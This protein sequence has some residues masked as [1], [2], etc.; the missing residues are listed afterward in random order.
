MI[1]ISCVY[2]TGGWC[3]PRELACVIS[4]MRRYHKRDEWNLIVLTDDTELEEHLPVLKE[5]NFRIVPFKHDWPGWWSKIELFRPDLAYYR[6]SLYID[7]DTSIVGHLGELWDKAVPLGFGMLR[8]FYYP[9][10]ASG[11]MM[12]QGRADLCRLYQSFSMDPKKYMQAHRST[13][14]QGYIASIVTEPD[15]YFQDLDTDAILTFKP[16]P[17]TRQ[18]TLPKNTK[19]ICFHGQ[20]RPGDRESKRHFQWVRDYY[21]VKSHPEFAPRFD[22]QTLLCAGTGPTFESDWLK[23]TEKYPDAKIASVGYAAG[24]VPADFVFSD[25][26]EV[27]AELAEIRKKL[28]PEKPWTHHCPEI[29]LGAM[30][31]FNLPNMTWWD[32]SRSDATSIESAMRFG[33]CTGFEKVVLCGCPLVKAPVSTVRQVI[34]DGQVWPPPTKRN[35]SDEKLNMF[36]TALVSIAAQYKGRVFSMSGFTRDIFGLPPEFVIPP[37]RRL[38]SVLCPTRK[39]P[40]ALELMLRS[41]RSTAKG[42]VEVLLYIDP[43]EDKSEYGWVFKYRARLFQGKMEMSLGHIWNYLAS[44]SNGEY[45]MMANDDLNFLTPGWDIELKQAMSEFPDELG[46]AWADDQTGHAH[47]HCAFPTVSRRWAALTL[48]FCPT[49]FKFFCHDTWIFDVA[50]KIGKTR[51]LPD[52]KIEHRHFTN[53]KMPF[54]ET[55]RKNRESGQNRFD[56][57]RYEN[58]DPVRESQAMILDEFIQARV[59]L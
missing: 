41:L 24:I 4:G 38:I 36:R 19:I 45:L 22:G 34:K 6:P 59:G 49:E 53:N 12:L 31:E 39:R 16:T 42:P 33:A 10:P 46:V 23:A 14:D 56:M 1:S 28:E 18:R 40:E 57:T 27:H 25:H 11:V 43:D 20:P 48:G 13:G 44:K 17:K 9:R 29:M 54:D 47:K 51:Y 55:Y 21:G 26:Y 7:L 52:V 50:K 5:I 15:F 8:D 37:E 2:R 35:S 32:W 58:T 3:T 30:A